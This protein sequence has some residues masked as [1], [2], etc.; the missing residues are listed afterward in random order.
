M[1]E[2]WLTSKIVVDRWEDKP[3]VVRRLIAP[4]VSEFENESWFKTFH[5]L[6]Y[7]SQEGFHLLFGVNL[8]SAKKDALKA[9]I[10]RKKTEVNQMNPL[11]KSIDYEAEFVENTDV[12]KQE[13]ERFGKLGLE[14]FL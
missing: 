14:I 1:S 4:I 10:E 13:Q 9:S 3:E 5:F 8:D 7:G 12:L 11:I 6:S 2:T